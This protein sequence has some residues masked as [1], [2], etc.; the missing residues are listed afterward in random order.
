MHAFLDLFDCDESAAINFTT[1]QFFLSDE[2]YERTGQLLY[3][4]L[5]EGQVVTTE[6]QLQTG[7][8]ALIWC[9]LHGKALKPSVPGLGTIWLYQ[10]F[11]AE[12]A[13]EDALRRA[14]EIAEESSRTKTE[15]LANMSHELRTPMHAVSTLL[16][17]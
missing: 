17:W 10:D 7:Y 8:G 9:R 2:Q 16:A 5:N 11:S 4:Q 1:R 6:L 14:K 12:R 3:K 15:F 13:S